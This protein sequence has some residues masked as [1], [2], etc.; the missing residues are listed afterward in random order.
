MRT[1]VKYLTIVAL[2]IVP[3]TWLA[4]RATSTEGEDE[5]SGLDE[6]LNARDA[7]RHL[8]LQDENG[9]IPPNGLIDAYKQ[10]EGM[11]FL[12]EAWAEFAQSSQPTDTGTKPGKLKDSNPGVLVDLAEPDVPNP[13]PWV[14]IG[15]G[16]IGGRIRSIIIKPPNPIHPEAERTIWIGAVSGGVWK[17]TNG[18]GTWTT[19]TDFLANI[20]VHCMVIDPQNP[21][22]LY[23][24][25]GET[26]QGNGIFKTTN[27][28]TTWTR[29]NSTNNPNFNWV[30]S[31]AISPTNSQVLLAA[32]SS[33][34]YTGKIYRSTDAGQNWSPIT[35]PVTTSVVNVHFH[36]TDANKCIAGLGDNGGALY[37][38]TGGTTWAVASGFPVPS[39]RVEV[40]YA[41]GEPTRV[42]ASVSAN[43]GQLYVS[44]DEAHGF[45][46]VIPAP[47]F[48]GTGA[49]GYHNALWVDPI[50]A[51]TVL[52]GGAYLSRSTDGGVHWEEA[53]TTGIHLDHHVIVEDPDYNRGIGGNG[54]PGN[55]KVYG[56]NDGG[57]HLA[58]NILYPCPSGNCVAGIGWQ[59]K[60]NDLAITQ[61]YGAAAHVGPPGDK[62]IGGTQDNGTLVDHH[63]F[64]GWTMMAGALGGDGGRCAADQ[65]SDPYFYGEFFFIQIYR[66][67]NGGETKQ[68]IYNGIADAAHCDQTGCYANA[69][70]PMILDPNDVTGRT[71]LAGGRRLWRSTNVRNLPPSQPSWAPIKGETQANGELRNISAIAVA[72]DNS[73][74]IWVGHNDG[75]I[76]YTTNGMD[77]NPTWVERDAGLPH[78]QG[79]MCTS[80]TIGQANGGLPRKVY[81][82]FGG[83]FPSP[84]ESR[85]NIWKTDDD[86]L[87]WTDLSNG[88]P[89][90]PIHSV[91]ISPFNALRLY[92]GTEVGVFASANGGESW[93]PGNR[94]PANVPVFELFW[95]GPKLVAVTHGRG[96]FTISRVQ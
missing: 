67:I 89:S 12:V 62:I 41:R 38:V 72:P 78:G 45:A 84:T 58:S 39:G 82:T 88:L 9:E 91:V 21:D 68:Y 53:S 59:S 26:F 90:A 69:V 93:S 29:L 48:S 8:Q 94:G 42:Y 52:A 80:I 20:G 10:K 57:I 66:S 81:A 25:T 51:D 49:D 34:N 79:H 50:D 86:G 11:P 47:P 37:S 64:N 61:F 96:I 65:T 85:G 55:A 5:G 32:A 1:P 71:M 19:S 35:I 60:N 77:A 31:L 75:S 17:S 18:G 40:A 70:A 2:A 43:N 3:L 23:A 28:G 76:Y 44:F 56:G 87:T 16:N 74:A 13:D 92:L 54:N 36:P 33:D 22:I 15:P 7:F 63:L 73:N 30:Y 95:M 46:R 14:S 6:H 24:G 27:G 4:V 83:F